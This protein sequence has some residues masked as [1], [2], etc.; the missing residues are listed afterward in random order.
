[1]AK[2]SMDDRG[3][4]LLGGPTVTLMSAGIVVTKKPQL[5]LKARPRGTIKAAACQVRGEARQSAVHERFA[6]G[7]IASPSAN[8]PKEREAAGR[9]EGCGLGKPAFIKTEHCSTAGW[10][11]N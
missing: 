8:S 7:P 1:M 9:A 3:A 5:G 2:S 11:R 10:L 6:I 4:D